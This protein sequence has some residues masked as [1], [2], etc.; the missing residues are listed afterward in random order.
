MPA[1]AATDR[2]LKTENDE[3]N[4]EIY[5]RQQADTL[6]RQRY[7]DSQ[8]N[9]L[10]QPET[11]QVQPPLNNA[12]PR[13]SKSDSNGQELANQQNQANNAATPRDLSRQLNQN[14]NID[15]NKKNNAP[16]PI[17]Q[18]TGESVNPADLAF[19]ESTRAI[20]TSLWAAV[21]T[22]YTTLSL[23]GL[24]VYLL[25]SLF[26]SK[27]AQFG[28]DDVIGNWLGAGRL[29]NNKEFAKYIEII[30]LAV[31]DGLILFLILLIFSIIAM[32]LEDPFG[33]LKQAGLGLWDIFKLWWKYT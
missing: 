12:L 11:P 32:F 23:W 17:S 22:D 24:H 31:L 1:I 30:I 21:W 26:S 5:P 7:N 20:L 18:A 15:R 33:F 25:G 27:V 10:R 28:E 29:G 3:Q 8:K 9:R 13:D 2:D 14:R 6:R 16:S 4:R 19:K